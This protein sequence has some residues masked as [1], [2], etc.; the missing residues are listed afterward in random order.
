M[1]AIRRRH[2]QRSRGQALV[3][4]ALILPILL[5]LV[6]GVIDI[7]RVIFAHVQLQEATHEGAMYGAYM[8]TP[9]SGVQSR[10]TNSS[11]A[12]WVS[13]ATVTVSCTTSPAPGR[14][15][16]SSTYNLTLLTPIV[17]DLLGVSAVPLSSTAIATNFN[18]AC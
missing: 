10:V 16:V 18:E 6:M 15:T 13:G 8:P 9:T 3:E 14:V 11:D 5:I 7:G 17:P 12:D 2:Q 4:T 1:L